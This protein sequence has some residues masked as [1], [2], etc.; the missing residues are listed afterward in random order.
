MQQICL[1]TAYLGPV[2][3]YSALVKAETV[4]LENCEYYL[5]QTYRN[6]CHIAAANGP[7][8]LSIPVEKAS[9]EKLLTRDV[10]ISEHN[11]W[12]IQHWRSIES[13]YN[14]TPF[15]EY[16]KDDLLPFYEKKWNFLW[17]FN[18]EIQS[19]I[20]E[21]L[22]LQL[23]IQLTREYKATLDE[24][25]L[26]LRESI[27]PKKENPLG[28]SKNY[29]QV[30]EQRFGFQPN[31]SIIDLLLNMGNESQLIISPKTPKGGL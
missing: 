2:E 18:F 11:D 9:G 3:Y 22:D 31:M 24:N 19:K 25:T 10:R 1:S 7:M 20:L 27:H 15:F 23:E 8:A 28:V 21:L 30:F 4:F 6:R 13:A 17:D 5:K 12:Q 14:S 29:Y 16:Y 26:D